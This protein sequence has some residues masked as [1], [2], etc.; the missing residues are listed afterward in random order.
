MKYKSRAIPLTYIKQGDSSIISKIFT[1]EKGL[2][3]FIVKGV[4]SKNSKKR[5]SYFE[6]LKLLNINANFNAKKSLQHLGDV[7]ISVNFEVKTNKMHKNFIGFF[8]AEVSS[9]VL[10]ENE[11]SP[12]LFN[13]IWNTTS[14]LYGSKKVDP[15]FAIK[16]LLNLSGFLGFYPSTAKINKP[17]FNLESGEFSNKQS[18][19]KMC[20]DKEK[21]NYLKTLLNNEEALIPQE[22]KSELLKELLLFY[23]LHHYNLDSIT[24]HLVIK[25]LRK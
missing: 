9:K 22:K 13:F 11:Q 20:L 1:E 12:V 16:Y 21:S 14:E 2:Q 10:Q 15:N 7:A 6:P 17:F 24:S 25:T 19:L 4:R 3:T 8:I 18:A 5:L 23:R